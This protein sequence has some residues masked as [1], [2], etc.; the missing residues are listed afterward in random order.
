[1]ISFLTSP[2]VSTVVLPAM[3]FLLAGLIR[4]AYKQA[5]NAVKEMTEKVI[6]KIEVVDAKVEGVIT[7]Q[8]RVRDELLH[9]GNTTQA[10]RERTARL[11]GRAE[12]RATRLQEDN[13]RAIETLTSTVKDPKNEL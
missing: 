12:E 10:L 1:M 13:M 7:E 6:D 8:K 11:E 2:I 4:Y 5:G 3:M 9:L